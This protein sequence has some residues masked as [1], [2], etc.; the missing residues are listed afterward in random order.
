MTG[1]RGPG[2]APRR[3]TRENLATLSAYLSRERRLRGV[4][5]A[6]GSV[7]FLRLPP[8]LDGD[9][10]ADHLRQHYSTLVVPGRFF[11]TPRAVRVSFGVPPEMFREGLSRLS[12]ALDDLL[13]P[14]GM[15][16]RHAR[17]AR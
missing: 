2:R 3:M 5:P 13:E 7:A 14:H 16:A 10:L 8:S 11:E 15:M 12:R 4:V 6:G 17:D 1:N 9:A